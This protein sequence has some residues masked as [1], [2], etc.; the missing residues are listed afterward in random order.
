TEARKLENLEAED[1]G[2]MLVET[3]RE[4]ENHRKEKLEPRPEGTLCL[5]NK[6]W[7]PCF[8]DLRNLIMHES[9]NSKYSV[10]LGSDKMYQDIKKLY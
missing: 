10:H 8:G 5:N 7:L 2:G 6:R 4:S 1:V 9:H 3:S